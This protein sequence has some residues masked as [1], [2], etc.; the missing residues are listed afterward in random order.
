M[1]KRKDLANVF[2]EYG[3][4][5]TVARETVKMFAKH[6]GIDERHLY[7]AETSGNRP[8]LKGTLDQNKRT[9]DRPTGV[10]FT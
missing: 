2:E 5:D 10:A 1:A 6:I 3:L 9:G 7:P 8:L 4:L